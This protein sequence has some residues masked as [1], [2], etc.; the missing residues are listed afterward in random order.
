MKVYYKEDEL[1]LRL[2]EFNIKNNDTLIIAND[3][4]FKNPF[5]NILNPKINFADKELVPILTKINYKTIPSY[6][7]ICK[8]T[9]K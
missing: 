3:N 6:S 8:M 5:D 7:E 1:K 4:I 9:E 2:N